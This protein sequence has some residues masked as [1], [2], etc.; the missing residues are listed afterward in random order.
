MDTFVKQN[1]FRN[2]AL[3]AHEVMMQEMNENQ[4]A[5]AA[6]LYSCYKYTQEY[7]IEDEP[8]VPE[9]P[10]DQKPVE[11]FFKMSKNFIK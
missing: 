7:K 8:E 6:S 10:E 2:A 11:F 1:A 4:I 9:E 3:V 5:L